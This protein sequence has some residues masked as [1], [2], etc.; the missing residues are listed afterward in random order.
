M[1]PKPSNP[2]SDRAI[3]TINWILTKAAKNTKL[4]WDTAAELVFIV[5]EDREDQ[6]KFM[7]WLQDDPDALLLYHS[8]PYNAVKKWQKLNEKERAIKNA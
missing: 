2:E 8:S 6:I 5:I 1:S 4:Y 7:D 3:E